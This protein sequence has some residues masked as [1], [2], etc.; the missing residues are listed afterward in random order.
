MRCR[1]LIL[2]SLVLL[3]SVP[4]AASA[5]PASNPS[6]PKPELLG[7]FK[8]WHVFSVGRGANR[9]CYA[10]SEP[11]DTNPAN[12][13]RDKISFLISTWPGRKV[14]NEPSVVPGRPE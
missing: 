1:A 3:P 14:R 4:V 9:L 6:G 8:D 2:F 11:R 13:K 5:A 7:D 10:L 12:V